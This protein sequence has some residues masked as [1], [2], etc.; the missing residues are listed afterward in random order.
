MLA[1]KP[2]LLL[3]KSVHIAKVTVLHLHCSSGDVTVGEAGSAEVVA[4]NADRA[5]TLDVELSWYAELLTRSARWL[6]PAK[7]YV[8]QILQNPAQRWHS[9][10]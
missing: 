10:H 1:G 5:R 3:P 6:F 2:L 4:S 8:A 9:L 7:N